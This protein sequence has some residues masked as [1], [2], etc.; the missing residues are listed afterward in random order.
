M[1][2][3]SKITVVVPVYKLGED[4]QVLFTNAIKSIETQI[5][6]P[7]EVLIVVGKND[8]ESLKYVKSFDFGGL[9]NITRIIENNGE[10]DFCSQMNL[11]VENVKTEYFTLLEQDDEF[12]R[13]LFKNAVE[14]IKSYPE[15]GAFLPIIVDVNA[16]EQFMSFTNE[17]VLANQ[18]SD[19]LGYLD[20]NSLLVYQNFSIDGMI[21]KTDVY[22]ELGGLKSKIVLTFV[23]EFLLRLTHNDIKVMTLPKFGYKHRNLLPG[24]LFQTYKDTLT[25]DET[26]WW[27]A[28]AKKEY[29]FDYDRVITYEK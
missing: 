14:Y 28:Q 22:K 24:S 6:L 25:P 17:A 15:V 7:E 13:I 16:D 1:D 3:K 27:L 10:T 21:M 26:K 18:F 23:Y 19:E 5:V 8:T 29:Y 11:G 9:K 12:S 20:L 4:R 2:N